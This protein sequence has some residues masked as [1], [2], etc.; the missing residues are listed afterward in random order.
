MH[1]YRNALGGEN[2]PLT[3]EY[4]FITGMPV[5]DKHS[6]KNAYKQFHPVKTN[7]TNERRA[8]LVK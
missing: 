5:M 6:F 2:C 8:A 4:L 1:T 3:M 7:D